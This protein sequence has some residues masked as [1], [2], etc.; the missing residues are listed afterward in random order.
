MRFPP[1]FPQQAV[2]AEGVNE[3][4]AAAM[5][6]VVAAPDSEPESENLSEVDD[7]VNPAKLDDADREM[8]EKFKQQEREEREEIE[9]E[10][11]AHQELVSY[12]EE[13]RLREKE[14]QQTQDLMQQKTRGHNNSPGSSGA[15]SRPS[16]SGEGGCGG[17]G[18]GGG[19]EGVGGS[20][21]SSGSN[22]NNNNSVNGGRGGLALGGRMT[23]LTPDDFRAHVQQAAQLAALGVGQFSAISPHLGPHLSP[24]DL[25]GLHPLRAAGM[26]PTHGPFATGGGTPVPDKYPRPPSQA[27]HPPSSLRSSPEPGNDGRAHHW[28][29]EEQFKQVP[30]SLTLTYSSV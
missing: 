15:S 7:E 18:G 12:Q 19:A 26:L 23:S 3:T 20:G 29:F 8:Y 6:A 11:K 17:G 30:L 16:S 14:L 1:R 10:L 4:E 21:H 24:R 27:T 13:L 22:N 2:G 25:N 5:S 9:R 28:T